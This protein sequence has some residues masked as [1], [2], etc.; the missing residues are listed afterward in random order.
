MELKTVQLLTII[1]EDTIADALTREIMAAGAKGYTIDSVR[2]QGLMRARLSEWE[3]EN[4]RIDT[5]VRR[6]VAMRILERL[7]QGYFH[8]YA[9]TAFLTPAEVVRPDKYG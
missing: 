8:T 1:A 9:I 2:G 3:G 5:L 4:V 7:E 6:D